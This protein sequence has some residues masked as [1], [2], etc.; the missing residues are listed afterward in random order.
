MNGLCAHAALHRRRRQR[1]ARDRRRP[2]SRSARL[3]SMGVRGWSTNDLLE[4]LIALPEQLFY[5][6]GIAAC[7]WV[8]RPHVPDAWIDTTR[9]DPH[10]GEVGIGAAVGSRSSSTGTSTSTV[11]L[12]RWRRSRRTTSSR[13]SRRSWP[14][15]G[16]SRSDDLACR[17][18]G[19][20]GSTPCFRSEQGP[21]LARRNWQLQGSDHVEAEWSP[22]PFHVAIVGVDIGLSLSTGDCQDLPV[23]L[24]R[25]P[26]TAGA[27][28]ERASAASARSILAGETL[29]DDVGEF[30]GGTLIRSQNKTRFRLAPQ[31]QWLAPSNLAAHPCAALGKLLIRASLTVTAPL[32]ANPTRSA[33][34][35]LSDSGRFSQSPLTSEV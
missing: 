17:P 19:W 2:I 18:G 24:E 8:L 32:G 13:W 9:R 27:N 31:I 12:A 25:S 22:Q 33:S 29:M 21:L 5:N 23:E 26:R 3:L 4:A 28:L 1:G 6:T 16:R 35:G 14:C 7:V 34:P 15:C 30:D 11:R 20:T 10:D